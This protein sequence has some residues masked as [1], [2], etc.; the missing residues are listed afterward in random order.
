MRSEIGKNQPPSSSSA[1]HLLEGSWV[2][3]EESGS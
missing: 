1:A 3:L 2:A